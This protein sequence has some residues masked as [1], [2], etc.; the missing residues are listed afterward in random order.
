M[1]STLKK[2]E[3]IKHG[4][5]QKKVLVICVG[6]ILLD[7]NFVQ[8]LATGIM[9]IRNISLIGSTSIFSGIVSFGQVPTI[10]VARALTVFQF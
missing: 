6:Y 7:F 8:F 1:L 3:G 2:L 10:I 5:G 4:N 9:S